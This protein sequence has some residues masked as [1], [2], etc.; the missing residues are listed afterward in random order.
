MR[1]HVELLTRLI[2]NPA[3]N[4][5]EQLREF[6]AH[7]EI[8]CRKEHKG[9]NELFVAWD[10]HEAE[11]LQVKPA[12]ADSGTDLRKTPIALAGALANHRQLESVRGIAEWA[13]RP[14]VGKA[15][16]VRL[17]SGLEPAP[18]SRDE[19]VPWYFRA[20]GQVDVAGRRELPEAAQEKQS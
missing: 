1:K 5:A 19:L 18:T 6:D 3:D 9:L 12:R 7:W 2:E 8:L 15:L 4:R 20:V 10:G 14:V 17:V 11:G 13:S 16:G